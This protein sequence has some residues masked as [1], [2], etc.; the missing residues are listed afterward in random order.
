M[1]FKMLIKQILDQQLFVDSFMIIKLYKYDN[2]N[3]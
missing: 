3:R 1:P 2:R